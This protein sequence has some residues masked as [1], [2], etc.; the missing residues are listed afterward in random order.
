MSGTDLLKRIKKAANMTVFP[1]TNAFASISHDA[2]TQINQQTNISCRKIEIAALGQQIIPQRYARNMKTYS[3]KDQSILLESAVAVV[4]LGG[5]GGTTIELLARSGIGKLTLIDGDT[6][7]ESNFNRQLLSSP[8]VIGKPKAQ[9]ALE[10]INH[11][12]PSVEVTVYNEYLNTDNCRSML[13]GALIVVDCLD[14]L[15]T[16]FLLEQATK[17]MN[18]PFVFGAVGGHTGQVM[19]IFPEDAGLKKIYGELTS[20]PEKGVETELGTI[21]PVVFMVAS[22][23]CAEVIKVLLNRKNI[24][25]NKLLILDPFDALFDILEI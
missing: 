3:V 20:I 6:F 7:E 13:E 1:D 12:N 19:T 23:Q 11:I 24:L 14:N 8:S 18:I 5:L 2:V 10:H 15:K 4:G 25:K 17:K 21:A 9:I 22:A 16:R